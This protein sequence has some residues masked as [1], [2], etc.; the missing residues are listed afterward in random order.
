MQKNV[1]P[2]DPY[3]PKFRNYPTILRVTKGI[4]RAILWL[5]GFSLEI[6][7]FENAEAAY[8]NAVCPIIVANHVSYLDIFLVAA[9]FGPYFPVARGDMANWVRR[10]SFTADP[11]CPPT[12]TPTQTRL[13][14]FPM[15]SRTPRALMGCPSC[16]SNETDS[17][18]P[19]LASF[20]PPPSPPP[21]S[22]PCPSRVRSLSALIQPV[23][24]QLIG[25]WGFAGVK[26]FSSEASG[27]S[28]DGQAQA[29]PQVPAPSRGEGLIA[30]LAPRV[31]AAGP[32]SLHPPVLIF[33]EGTC[34]TGRALLRF[35]TGAFVLGSPVLPVAFQYESTQN[36]GWVWARPVQSSIWRRVPRTLVQLFRIVATPR[37]RIV[38]R[39][40]E[41]LSALSPLLSVSSA[42]LA[43]T[44][45]EGLFGI[46]RGVAFVFFP[47]ALTLGLHFNSAHCF[48]TPLGRCRLAW[49]VYR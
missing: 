48:L 31:K 14:L 6:R 45:R 20:P 41:Q 19:P 5:F 12:H 46:Q 4:N 44:R 34:T 29:Q 39:M 26:G 11:T 36:C 33:P 1:D 47:F 40:Q 17:Q 8:A 35:K 15:H 18:C 7:G 24:G 13:L 38:V 37:K 49:L 32:W 43:Y 9:V 2:S 25:L 23:F 22:A 42:P 28:A 21:V 3:R 30:R 16:P 27:A 10:P